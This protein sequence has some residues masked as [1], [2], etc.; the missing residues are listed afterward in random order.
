MKLADDEKLKPSIG[1]CH[2]SEV[3]I[4]LQATE[5]S[6]DLSRVS[7]AVANRHNNSVEG[8]NSL[9][10]LP[11]RWLHRPKGSGGQ[12]GGK[13]SSTS[14]LGNASSLVKKWVRTSAS[15]TQ[16]VTVTVESMELLEKVLTISRPRTA[17]ADS[18]LKSFL[19]CHL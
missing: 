3:P 9:N 10:E 18:L 14:D 19:S 6:A 7:S 1:T 5:Q 4:C 16:Q 12:E 15:T 11:H 2:G 8:L 13:P 17:G